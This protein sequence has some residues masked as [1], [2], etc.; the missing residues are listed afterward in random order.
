M[1]I[2]SQG[3]QT[4]IPAEIRK[5]YNIEAGDHLVWIDD[6]SSIRVIPV[7]LP[8][9]S[10]HEHEAEQ[11]LREENTREFAKEQNNSQLSRIA[12]KR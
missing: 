10:T 6:G 2:V 9:T 4:V 7:L 11:E 8:V 3:G 5:R 1:G 12:F